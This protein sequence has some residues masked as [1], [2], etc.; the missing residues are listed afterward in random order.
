MEGREAGSPKKIMWLNVH[1]DK[2]PSNKGGGG[3]GE[4]W[5]HKKTGIKKLKIGQWQKVR[6]F[7]WNKINAPLQAN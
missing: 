7:R 1:F 3:G 4:V 5:V 6:V 2:I